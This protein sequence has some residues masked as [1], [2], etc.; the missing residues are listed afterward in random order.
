MLNLTFDEAEDLKIRSGCPS[1]DAP[2]D[3]PAGHR[4]ADRAGRAGG[5]RARGEQ[6]HR[7]GPPFAR[8]LPHAGDPGAHHQAHL[9]DRHRRPAAQP[10][11]L[12]REG[13]SD[14]GRPRRSACRA[15]DERLG[16]SERACRS[17]G[18]CRGH[19][20]GAWEGWSRC[21]ASTCSLARYSTATGIRGLVPL[22]LHHHDRARARSCCSSPPASTCS[23]S[24]RATSCRPL[25]TP[26]SKYAEQGKAFDVFE[27]KEQELAARQAIAQTALADRINLGKIAEEISLVLPDEVWL[28][29][30][31]LGSGERRVVPGKHAALERAQSMNVAYKSI[32]KT[33]V[34]LNELR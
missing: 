29:S 25:R 21:C 9:P 16:R 24:R 11:E 33:L 28:D 32:A 34:R 31:T 7:R 13:P 8:L 5:A 15:A 22:R 30:L 14:A 3:V 12:P 26:R 27:K 4:P 19:R 10:A 23:F 20:A 2:G 1:I 6:V 17:H 18:M